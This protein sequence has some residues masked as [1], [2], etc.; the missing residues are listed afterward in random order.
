MLPGGMR[1]ADGDRLVTA[2]DEQVSA[3]RAE[4]ED[5]CRARAAYR[6]IWGVAPPDADRISLR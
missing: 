1:F 2:T 6:L 3:V 5:R 4:I